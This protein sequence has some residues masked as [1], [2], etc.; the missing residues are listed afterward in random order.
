MKQCIPQGLE[1][2]FS[3]E[4]PSTIDGATSNAFGEIG[5]FDPFLLATV[6]A[7]NCDSILRTEPPKTLGRAKVEFAKM[8]GRSV[9]W[10]AATGTRH[11]LSSLSA[12]CSPLRRVSSGTG[13][14]TI[15]PFAW[16]YQIPPLRKGIPAVVASDSD[17]LVL[18]RIRA[19]PRKAPA[20]A[21]AVQDRCRSLPVPLESCPAQC[22][23]ECLGWHTSMIGCGSQNV[24]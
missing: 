4:S 19:A 8:G 3:S 11:Y 18:S 1:R 5:R 23:Y 17:S 7:Y 24:K 2:R 16:P 12:P 15:V 14:A 22:T 13:A 6:R 10:F 21:G 9:H 20:F